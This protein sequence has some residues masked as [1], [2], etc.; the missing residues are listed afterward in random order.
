MLVS[1]HL[2][3]LMASTLQDVMMYVN[4]M[5][6]QHSQ[7]SK[8]RYLGSRPYSNKK[9]FV[10]DIFNAYEYK[11]IPIKAHGIGIVRS[12][13]S[14]TNPMIPHH[15]HI[16]KLTLLGNKDAKILYPSLECGKL[17]IYRKIH[18][19]KTLSLSLK[20]NHAYMSR[21]TSTQCD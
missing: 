11:I 17:P 2:R 9:K 5:N 16:S 20:H 6:L 21:T 10:V 18:V 13:G 8:R 7:N 14:Y 15:F 12:K 4:T 3:K 1:L 19:M